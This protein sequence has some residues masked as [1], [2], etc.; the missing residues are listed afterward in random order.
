VYLAI[1]L[2]QE[3][4][5]SQVKFCRVKNLSVKTFNYWYIKYKREKG[6]P[7]GRNNEVSDTFIPVKVYGDRTT[8]VSGGAYGRIAV[9]F[10]KFEYFYIRVSC[11]TSSIP[12]HIH[13][14]HFLFT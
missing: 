14:N 8:K 1:E 2:W 9:S 3:S 13:V 12:L 10:P 4:G 5:L 7:S 6:L 11:F